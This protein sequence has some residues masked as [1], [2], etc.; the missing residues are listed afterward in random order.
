MPWC[1][2]PRISSRHVVKQTSVDGCGAACGEMLLHDR[3]Q[4]VDQS[5][6]AMAL[7][8]PTDGP[9][10]AGCLS[11]VSTIRW[12]GGVLARTRPPNWDFVAAICADY[13]SWAALLEPG[14]PTEVGHWVV[15]DGVS[16]DGLVL[17][18]DPAVGPYG[19]PM[20][21]FLDLWRYTVVVLPRST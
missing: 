8:E 15:V 16:A 21:E 7:A 13:S 10:L 9:R 20:E 18:R 11:D 4:Q 12:M 17:V 2:V 14:G 1:R 6:L 19:I 3:G 5:V